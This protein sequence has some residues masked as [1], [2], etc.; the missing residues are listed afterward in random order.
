M[1]VGLFSCNPHCRI[2]ALTSTPLEMFIDRD[3]PDL[4]AQ[5]DA[6][7]DTLERMPTFWQ[8]TDVPVEHCL[9]T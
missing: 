2:V 9:T 7:Y 8:N 5:T 6:V 1:R 3:E 4:V